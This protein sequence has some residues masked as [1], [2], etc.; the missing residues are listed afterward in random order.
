VVTAIAVEIEAAAFQHFGS[1]ASGEYKGKIKQLMFNL[2][3]PNNPDLR[4]DMLSG[5]VRARAPLLLRSAACGR[6]AGAPA[7]A[8]PLHQQHDLRPLS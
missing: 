8:A 3:D 5:Q 7:R 6:L 2:R 4:G 1:M